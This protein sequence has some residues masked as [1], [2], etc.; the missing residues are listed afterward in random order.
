MEERKDET[1]WICSA[2]A[3]RRRNSRGMFCADRS[4][5]ADITTSTDKRA[6]GDKA[7]RSDQA[8]GSN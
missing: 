4:A 6:G 3:I 1:F 2:D 7:A 8:A 5:Q